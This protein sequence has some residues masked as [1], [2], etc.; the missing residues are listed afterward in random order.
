MT[1]Q[2]EDKPGFG[3][4]LLHGL[5]W[6]L[7][8]LLRLVFVVII[9]AGLGLGVYL[10][11]VYGVQLFDTQ[12]MQPIRDNSQ[13]IDDLQTFRMSDEETLELR[14]V[15]MQKQVDA[16]IAQGDNQREYLDSMD[17]R[18]ADAE[19]AVDDALA[20]VETAQ[21]DLLTL[22]AETDD[23][24]PRLDELDDALE[25]LELASEDLLETLGAVETELTEIAGKVDDDSALTVMQ[26]DVMML[27]AMESLTRARLFLSQDNVGLASEEIIGARDTLLILKGM[28]PD[29]QKDAVQAILQRLDLSRDNLTSAPSIAVDDLEAAWQL[30][31]IGLPLTALEV[32]PS[33]TLTAT[34]TLTVTPV[35]TG[36]VVLT[37]TEVITP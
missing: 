37:A 34:G 27:K 12:L 2:V 36:T 5:G 31:L 29:F 16:L 33:D 19:D 15:T 32:T 8:F 4:R 28:V 3:K 9:G 11:A 26:Y 21:A 13:R 1:T 17:S 35:I 24:P 6:F 25:V 23:L 22:T 10:A 14:L 18:L 20:N 30:L 7:K